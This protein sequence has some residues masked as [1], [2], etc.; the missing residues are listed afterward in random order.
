MT[1]RNGCSAQNGPGSNNDFTIGY[2][3]YTAPSLG[4][5]FPAL[6]RAR[7]GSTDVLLGPRPFLPN[8]RGGWL[9]FVRLAPSVLRRD[10]TSPVR[11]CPPC[12]FQP[13]RTGLDPIRTETS[14]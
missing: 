14:R 8:L 6:C 1:C 7:V 9:P 5:S 2:L 13:S 4:H 10:P 12:G 3:P 11:A